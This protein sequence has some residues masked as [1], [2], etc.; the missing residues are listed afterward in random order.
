MRDEHD[1]RH[2]HEWEVNRLTELLL[3]GYTWRRVREFMQLSKNEFDELL[4]DA[5]GRAQR[6]RRKLEA[7]SPELR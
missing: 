4:D 6:A 1:R 7:Q 3:T 2:V 5:V